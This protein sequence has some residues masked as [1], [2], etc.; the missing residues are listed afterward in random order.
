M[1]KL[2]APVASN[3]TVVLDSSPEDITWISVLILVVWS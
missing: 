3:V 2:V 1:L